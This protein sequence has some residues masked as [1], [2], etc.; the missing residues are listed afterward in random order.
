MFVQSHVHEHAELAWL[1]NCIATMGELE[2]MVAFKEKSAGRES[3]SVGLFTYPV[4]QA[5][6][7]LLYL[8]DRVPVGEDQRQHLE[9][10]RD[11]AQ[12]FNTRYGQLFPPPQA[13]IPPTAARIS[14]LQEPERKMSTSSLSSEDGKLLMLDEPDVIRR[15]FKRAVTDSGSEIRHDWET[16]P[17]VSNLLEILHGVTGEPIADARGELRRQ[18]LRPPQDRRRRGRDRA[19]R[20]DPGAPRGADGRPGRARPP[21][22]ASA[23]RARRRSPRRCWP[24]RRPAWACC[25]APD[26]TPVDLVAQARREARRWRRRRAGGRRGRSAVTRAKRASSGGAGRMSSARQICAAAAN[27]SARQ[28]SSAAPA[29]GVAPPGQEGR[30]AGVVL[31]GPA[32]RQDRRLRG[33]HRLLRPPRGHHQREAEKL[34]DGL[35]LALARPHPERLDV[36]LGETAEVGVDDGQRVQHL[37]REAVVVAAGAEDATA[38]MLGRRRQEDRV[39]GDRGERRGR[40]ALRPPRAPARPGRARA[41]GCGS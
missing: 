14:D 40:A 29:A 26:A 15:K 11:I 31:A 20:A 37:R 7:I 9:L 19:P 13:A 38:R 36:A 39:V 33:R 18:G 17:G 5:A 4:L 22:G 23:P 10:A 35:R 2:R 6:D 1:F 16:K 8:A 28:D 3:V 30:R 27:S 41:G 34:L 25:P 21:D 12:R 32:A 24:R